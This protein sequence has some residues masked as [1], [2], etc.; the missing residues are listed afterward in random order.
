M[1]TFTM[2]DISSMGISSRTGS[3]TLEICGSREGSLVGLKR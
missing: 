2:L 3:L 1:M